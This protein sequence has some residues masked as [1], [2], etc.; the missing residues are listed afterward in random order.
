MPQVIYEY[1]V[2]LEDVNLSSLLWLDNFKSELIFTQSEA[3]VF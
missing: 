3:L 2:S 1:R